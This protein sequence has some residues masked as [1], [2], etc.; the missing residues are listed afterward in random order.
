G[1]GGDGDSGGGPTAGGP[2]GASDTN[3]QVAGVDEAD[4]VKVVDNGSA[5]FVLHGNKLH[6]LAS[7]P[8]AE[9]ALSPE[10]LTI[11]GSPSEMFVT[12]DGKAVIFSSVWGYGDGSSGGKYDPGFAGDVACEPGFGGCYSYGSSF[13]KITI[14]DVSGDA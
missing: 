9:T 8:A 4:F 6:K 10:S 12:A 7:W 5:M 14:A 13:T 2:T 3:N 11:E 1:S